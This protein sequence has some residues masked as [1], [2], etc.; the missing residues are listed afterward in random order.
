MSIIY[1]DLDATIIDY[2]K[3]NILS[4]PEWTNVLIGVKKSLNDNANEIIVTS[5]YNGDITKV[6]RSASLVLEIYAH[7]FETANTLSLVVDSIIRNA[8]VGDIK[9]VEVAIGPVR[10][11]EASSAEKR[12][13][14]VDLVVQATQI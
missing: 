4:I 12:S 7:D 9:K 3:T 5:S 13:L 11:T 1:S 6:T 10:T 8:T 2:L 14:S